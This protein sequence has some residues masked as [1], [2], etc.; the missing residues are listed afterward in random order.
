MTTTAPHTNPAPSN[1]GSSAP[2]VVKPPREKIS[3]AD[4][5]LLHDDGQ[6]AHTHWPSNV[7]D[8]DDVSLGNGASNEMN[9]AVYFMASQ[10]RRKTFVL[11]R[12]THKRCS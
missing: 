4:A 1:E 5:A 10:V 12:F 9:E 6:H 8:D 7:D 11:G 3:F 2:A